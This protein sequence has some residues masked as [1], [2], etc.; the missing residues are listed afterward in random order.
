MQRVPKPL[1]SA[2]IWLFC[3]QF[4]VATPEA[5]N[6]ARVLR[7][8]DVI[9]IMY[10]EGIEY[11][12]DLND[13]MLGGEGGQYWID[14]VKRLYDTD[15]MEE[16]LRKSIADGMDADQIS[17]AVTFFGSE[18]GQRILTLEI[19]ARTTMFD[20][21][22]EEL[23]RAIYRDLAGSEDAQLAAVSQ[24]VQ[25]NNLLEM[26]IAGA[27]TSSYQ[28]YRGLVDGKAMNLSEEEILKDVWGQ[29]QE[30]RDDTEG[31]LFGYL[32]MAY[33]PLNKD[34]L[35]SYITF[36]DSTAGRALN[37]ALF[38]GFDI[39]FNAISYELGRSV[40]RAMKASDL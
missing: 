24:F 36:S 6:L 10:E 39:M 16:T 15:R 29:E 31:W 32:L 30:I 34:E 25:V 33:R 1:L 12:S 4:A 22:I 11:A 28:F 19:S 23:A 7:I 27:L 2:L 37:Q 26:N 5:D 14:G 18:Q 13:D 8:S 9:A 17:Q 20:P 38:D 40:A 21:D 3:A 35:A